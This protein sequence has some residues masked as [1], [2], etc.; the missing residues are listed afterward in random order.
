MGFDDVTRRGAA[1]AGPHVALTVNDDETVETD[2][3]ST[4]RATRS[5]SK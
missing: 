2:A 1:L 3:N 5:V 4:E